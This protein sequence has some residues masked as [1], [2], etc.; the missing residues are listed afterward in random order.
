MSDCETS[1]TGEGSKVTG[2]R[3][4]FAVHAACIVRANTKPEHKGL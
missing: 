1:L 2:D 3:A 4:G